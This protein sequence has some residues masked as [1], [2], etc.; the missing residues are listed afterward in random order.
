M[1]FVVPVYTPASTF[2]ETAVPLRHPIIVSVCGRERRNGIKMAE[3][4]VGHTADAVLREKYAPPP[5]EWE[6]IVEIC[7]ARPGGRKGARSTGNGV[8]ISGS[9]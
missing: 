1:I 9:P 7:V 3:S 4:S 2:P 8:V 5:S 6:A